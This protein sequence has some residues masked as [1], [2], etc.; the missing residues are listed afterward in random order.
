M[1]AIGVTTGFVLYVRERR[2]CH[3]LACR[4]AASRFTFTLLIVA[5]L[6]VATTIALEMSLD[7]LERV[8]RQNLIRLAQE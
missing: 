3:A 5:G 8:L 1:P 2:R 7:L 4:M 6:V